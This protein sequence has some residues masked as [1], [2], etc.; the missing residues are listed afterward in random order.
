MADRPART[1]PALHIAACLKII[2]RHRNVPSVS[3]AEA[4][5]LIKRIA[6]YSD[7]DPRL[8]DETLLR[9]HLERSTGMKITELAARTDLRPVSA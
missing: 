1:K 6:H 9:E 4:R 5:D 3:V 2:A 8:K 7:T